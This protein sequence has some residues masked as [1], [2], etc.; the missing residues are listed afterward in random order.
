MLTRLWLTK[1]GRQLPLGLMSTAHIMHCLARIERTGW[2]REWY[3]ALVLEVEIRAYTG[4]TSAGR[5]A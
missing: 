2:R 4:R 1:D 3:E 5:P